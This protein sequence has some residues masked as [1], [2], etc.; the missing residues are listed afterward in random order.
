MT[1][2]GSGPV[3]PEDEI[4]GHIEFFPT[5][6][7]LDELELAYHVYNDEHHIQVDDNRYQ[8]RKLT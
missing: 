7:Y 2:S 1:T 5:V 6:S 3:T 8:V 4:L